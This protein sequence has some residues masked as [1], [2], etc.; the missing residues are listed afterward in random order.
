MPMLFQELIRMYSQNVNTGNS[1][2]DLTKRQRHYLH[3]L[4]NLAG[5]SGFGITSY[6]IVTEEDRKK[7]LQSMGKDAENVRWFL[8]TSQ[9]ADFDAMISRAIEIIRNI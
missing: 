7:I 9:E 1:D 8:S 6:A 5:N 4:L 3:V 2:T